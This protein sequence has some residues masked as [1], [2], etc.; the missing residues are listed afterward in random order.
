MGASRSSERLRLLVVDDDTAV[1]MLLGMELPSVEIL[2]ASRISEVSALVAATEPHAIA[3]DR[4]L[5]DG[6]GLDLVR[7]LRVTHATRQTPILLI[8]AGDTETDVALAAGADAYV[9][10][11][12]DSEALEQLVRQLLALP[13]EARRRRRARLVRALRHDRPA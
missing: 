5:P 6:D 13:P 1:R 12:V 9:P 11:P 8:S 10:K 2:E 4:R 7:L 3:V